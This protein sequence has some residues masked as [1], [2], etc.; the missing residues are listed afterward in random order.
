MT[1]TSDYLDDC[2]KKLNISSTYALAKIWEIS[3]GALNNY[4]SGKRIPD[5]F[6]CFKIAETLEIDAAYVIARIKSESEKDPK[7]AEYFRVFGGLLRKQAINIVLVLACVISL[8]NAPDT[9]DDNLYIA[10][11]ASAVTALFYE[12]KT[13]YNGL[14]CYLKGV[15]YN[16]IGYKEPKDNNQNG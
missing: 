9:G 7:K 15:L 10:I 11:S 6:A 14:L 16:L 8:V 12:I 1:I 5:E 2:K 13:S 4:Y 3:E